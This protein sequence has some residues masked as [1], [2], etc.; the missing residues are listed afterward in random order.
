MRP[1]CGKKHDGN[2]ESQ[3]AG[4]A[5]VKRAR[6]PQAED[7]APMRVSRTWGQSPQRVPGTRTLHEAWIALRVLFCY[8]AP[9]EEAKKEYGFAESGR[10]HPKTAP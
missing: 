1:L 10:A 8:H 5:F 7:S 9:C 6:L 2:W 3:G 4:T